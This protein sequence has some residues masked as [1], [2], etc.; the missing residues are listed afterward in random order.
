M[1]A[2]YEPSGCSARKA[3]GLTGL[4]LRAKHRDKTL[5]SAGAS[6]RPAQ[7]PGQASRGATMALVEQGCPGSPIFRYRSAPSPVLH[8]TVP[9]NYPVATASSRIIGNQ[10]CISRL[11]PKQ[12]HAVSS[13]KLYMSS[14]F[15]TCVMTVFCC[16][17]FLPQA[18][19]LLR[20][21]A[22]RLSVPLGK[23]FPSYDTG[24]STT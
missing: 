18:S 23:H 5:S 16:R 21:V 13:Q 15:S 2:C 20:V 22:A 14:D 10:L 3:Q 17:H 11:F 12:V 8:C 1:E 4:D 6:P 9:I 7:G 19:K 24:T